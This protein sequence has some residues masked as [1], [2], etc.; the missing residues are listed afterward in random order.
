MYSVNF[1]NFASCVYTTYLNYVINEN[2]E[3]VLVDKEGE[4]LTGIQPWHFS[5]LPHLLLE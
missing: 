3:V 4:M 5:F 1:L 2:N